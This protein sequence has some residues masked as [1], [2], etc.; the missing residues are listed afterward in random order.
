MLI[1]MNWI[2]K[3]DMTIKKEKV[4]LNTMENEIPD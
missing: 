4:E 1:G 2:Q 3:T